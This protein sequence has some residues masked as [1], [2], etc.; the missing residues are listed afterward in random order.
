MRRFTKKYVS[1]CLQCAHHEAPSGHK[2]G[3]LHPIPK[4]EVPFHTLHADHLGPFVRSKKGNV[5]IL[6]IVE[7]FTKFVN[8]R[9]VKDTKTATAI[10]IFKEYFSYFGAPSRLVTDRGSC[11]TSARFEEFTRSLNIKH[12]LN[13]VATPRANG[14][15]ERYNRT[16]SDALST[17]CHGKDENTWDDYVGDI[18]LGINTTMNKATGKSPSE[19]LFG[20]AS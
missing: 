19:L 18:Q 6:V 10:K 13:A 16:I 3:F 9:A 20:R 8:V 4:V 15:V 2:E 1:S 12:T 11:F 17:K 7:A 5:Y 14:Q